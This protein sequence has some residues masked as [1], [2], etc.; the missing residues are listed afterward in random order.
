M[1]YLISKL[2]LNKKYFI[3][4]IFKVHL[5]LGSL[6]GTD[7]GLNGPKK[8]SVHNQQHEF[9]GLLGISL[10]I[11]VFQTLGNT[12]KEPTPPAELSSTN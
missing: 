8:N 5:C 7:D 10:T 4:E 9:N 3:S 6:V 2:K 12:D 11:F 1:V